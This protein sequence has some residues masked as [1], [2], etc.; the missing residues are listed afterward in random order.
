WAKPKIA[1]YKKA[2]RFKAD[3]KIHGIFQS[4]RSASSSFQCPSK[5][6]A[7]VK[8]FSHYIFKLTSV[9]RC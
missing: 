8:V 2:V 1:V 6:V 7:G 4:D 9:T 3:W 5:T